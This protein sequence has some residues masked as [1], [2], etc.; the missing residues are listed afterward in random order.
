MILCFD[1]IV[2]DAAVVAARRAPDAAGTA[3]FYGDFEV[4]LSGFGGLDEGPAIG[5]GDGERVVFVVGFKGVDVTGIDLRVLVRDSR[6]K[7]IW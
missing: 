2:A 7:I 6:F 1:T 5:G 3:I 4:D